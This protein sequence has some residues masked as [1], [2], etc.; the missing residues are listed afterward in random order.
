[1][2]GD[3]NSLVLP[4]PLTKEH[5]ETAYDKTKTMK[6]AIDSGFKFSFATVIDSHVTT[7]ITGIILYQFGTGPIQGFALTLIIGIFT[8]LFGALVISRVLLDFMVE[9]GYKI[10][11]G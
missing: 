8:S 4:Y 7:L 9:K 6:A 3:D 11:L 2:V 10:T 5:L 1:M